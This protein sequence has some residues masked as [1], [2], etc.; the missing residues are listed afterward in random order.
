[1]EMNLCTNQYRDLPYFPKFQ[2]TVTVYQSEQYLR[3]TDFLVR[4]GL[5]G[6][7]YAEDAAGLR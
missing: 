6:Q 4:H 3:Q 5:Q 7:F 1:M 2:L